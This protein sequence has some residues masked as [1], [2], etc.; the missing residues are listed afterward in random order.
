MNI[1]NTNSSIIYNNINENIF[2]IDINE[3][4][5][6]PTNEPINY[7]FPYCISND[8]NIIRKKIDELLKYCEFVIQK[9][10]QDKMNLDDTEIKYHFE[11]LLDKILFY[12]YVLEKYIEIELNKEYKKLDFIIVSNISLYNMIDTYINNDSYFKDLKNMI[13][14]LNNIIENINNKIYT[15]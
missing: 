2:E 10:F 5:N 14:K 4:T 1:N 13:F 6:E 12:L 3:P 11:F 9:E 8:G 7:Y 15:V